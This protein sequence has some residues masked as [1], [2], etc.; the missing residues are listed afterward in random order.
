MVIQIPKKVQLFNL[1]IER[2]KP[3]MMI[4]SESFEKREPILDIE[5]EKAYPAEVIETQWQ[6]A[7]EVVKQ[8][9]PDNPELRQALLPVMTTP[10][11]DSITRHIS[12]KSSRT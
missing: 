8:D 2:Y 3:M 11:S 5:G 1:E 10:V 6:R 9:L 12:K 4:M 7:T